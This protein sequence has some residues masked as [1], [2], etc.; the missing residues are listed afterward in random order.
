MGKFTEDKTEGVFIWKLRPELSEALD[1]YD[2]SDIKLYADDADESDIRYWWLTA[3]PKIWSFGDLHV[4]GVQSYSFYNER[5]N[6]RRIFQN[7]LDAKTGDLI[8]GY[9]ASP[10]KQVVALGTVT[11]NDGERLYFE[12]TEGLVN[13]ISYEELKCCPELENMEFSPTQKEA[14]S[15]SP[16]TNMISS[17]T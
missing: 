15:N 5:G 13:P 1:R 17:S 10:T 3:N 8:I 9:D 11:E 4:G 12:K 14:C 16:K 2:L 7:F 6:K